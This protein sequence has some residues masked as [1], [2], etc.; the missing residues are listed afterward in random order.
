M[1]SQKGGNKMS[2]HPLKI[3]AM[4]YPKNN[5]QDEITKRRDGY[6]SYM[7]ALMINPMFKGERSSETYKLFL[8]RITP[9]EELLT[10]VTENSQKIMQLTADLPT[11]ATD[12][13]FL[14]MLIEEIKST[15]DIEGIESTTEEIQKAIAEAKKNTK[16]NTRLQSFAK[17]Y[18]MI[19]Q[20]KINKIEQPEDIRKLYD[21]LLKGEI[22]KSKEPDGQLFRNGFV[23]IGND[24]ATVHQPKRLENSFLPDI[25]A[26]VDF[27]NKK[28]LHPIYKAA[29]AHYYFE[30]IHPFYDGN[31][32]LG[33]YIF[34]SYIG[35]KLDPYT[36][37]SFS[38]EINSKK[39]NY[40]KAFQEANDKKNYGEVT[41]FVMEVLNYLVSG[42]KEVIQRLKTSKALLDYI[43]EMLANSD[44]NAENK[45]LLFYL[46]QSWLFSDIERGMEDRVLQELMK[47]QSSLETSK[48]KTK[49]LLDGLEKEAYITTTKGRPI[50]RELTPKFFEKINV[51]I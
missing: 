13:F 30:Y 14:G 6:G 25:N 50:I 31:G 10:T 42:Q 27:V 12:H 7:T 34:C 32:R 37:V 49:K 29:I 28:D 41:F 35:K 5:I 24:N 39:E 1:K 4:M 3:H 22:P 20:Q 9:L 26:W 38:H 46:S 36:A 33:R 48:S 18:L 2:Y 44:F 51:D 17:M 45:A 40:Y 47:N 8:V 43:S 19:Q 23:R 15:N 16:Q 21:F 11:V